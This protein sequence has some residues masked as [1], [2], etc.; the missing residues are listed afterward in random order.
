MVRMSAMALLVRLY[1]QSRREIPTV[2]NC[3]RLLLW[4]REN[5]LRFSVCCPRSIRR[6]SRVVLPRPSRPTTIS[7]MHWYGRCLCNT[8]HHIKS[9]YVKLHHLASL[10]TE[11]LY[12]HSAG[13]VL[14][15]RAQNGIDRLDVLLHR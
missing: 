10:C 8:S 11:I 1:T 2:V 7:L 15:T 9:L 6:P 4:R 5:R 14:K 12:I 13:V 3:V